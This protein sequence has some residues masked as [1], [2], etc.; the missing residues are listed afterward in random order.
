MPH[1]SAQL[2]RRDKPTAAH[3]PWFQQQQK[4]FWQLSGHWKEQPK[5]ASH[6]QL[7]AHVDPFHHPDRYSE[8]PPPAHANIPASDPQQYVPNAHRWNET[9]DRL[10]R[11]EVPAVVKRSKRYTMKVGEGHPFVPKDMKSSSGGDKHAVFEWPEY[12]SQGRRFTDVARHFQ[13]SIYAEEESQVDMNKTIESRMASGAVDPDD[14]PLYSSFTKDKMMP[15]HLA[16]PLEHLGLGGPH[17][18]SS[19]MLVRDPSHA[20]RAQQPHASS[21]PCL[22]GSD[23][24]ARSLFGVSL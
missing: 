3:G 14:K 4:P 9:A 18:P 16:A 13:K 15:R 6:K 11:F 23:L 17:S 10:P 19:R 20:T 2:W 22:L 12:P 8:H 5:Y 1:D 7:K 21:C 24:C